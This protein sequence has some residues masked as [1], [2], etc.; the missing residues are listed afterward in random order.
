MPNPQW[1]PG[2]KSIPGEVANTLVLAVAP[3]RGN[4]W[5]GAE[6]PRSRVL[7]VNGQQERDGKTVKESDHNFQCAGSMSRSY[8]QKGQRLGEEKASQALKREKKNLADFVI[9]FLAIR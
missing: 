3:G 5:E 9:L 6:D 2:R 8:T 1:S 4:T 7:K